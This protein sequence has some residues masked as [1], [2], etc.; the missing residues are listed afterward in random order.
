MEKEYYYT[1]SGNIVVRLGENDFRVL[2]VGNSKSA[3]RYSKMC[4]RSVLLTHKGVTS[5]GAI[6]HLPTSGLP[7]SCKIRL[8]YWKNFDT[9]RA[10]AYLWEVEMNGLDTLTAFYIVNNLW[11]K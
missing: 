7:L 2:Q 4:F 1:P 5:V 6:E 3:S 11:R 8:W 10:V 9:D